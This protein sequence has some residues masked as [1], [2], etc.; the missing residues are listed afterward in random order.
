LVV[1]LAKRGRCWKLGDNIH[2]DGDMIPLRF[3]MARETR[4][5][6]LREHLFA[7]IDPTL[8][9]R[10]A[11]GDIIIAGKGFGYGH[12]HPQPMF[13]LA[14]AG[15]G[16]VAASIPRGSFRNMVMAGVPFMTNCPLVVDA[17]SDGDDIEVDFATGEVRNYTTGRTVTTAPLDRRLLE[18]I[19]IGGWRPM[20]L[21]RLK[22]R[23]P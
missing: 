16:V 14:G 20:M 2:C 23:G 4:P 1:K 6:V 3:A 15:V 10:I 12:P 17:C 9:G 7:G 21:R 19:E 22:D 11:A 5:E 18:T 8:A 13:A